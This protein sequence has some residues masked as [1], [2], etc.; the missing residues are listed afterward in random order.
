[1][2]TDPITIPK[3][4]MATNKNRSPGFKMA[5]GYWDLPSLD[6]Q[7]VQDAVAPYIS[8]SHSE[9]AEYVYL[10]PR[11]SPKETC[12]PTS[13]DPQASSGSSQSLWQRLT[14]KLSGSKLESKH[15]PP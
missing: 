5:Q 10:I 3:R 11:E 7:S 4:T 6:D 1:M 15:D 2:T 13:K 14:S 9:D 12:K 8:K